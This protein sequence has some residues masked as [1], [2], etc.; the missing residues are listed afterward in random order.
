MEESKKQ[1]E[2]LAKEHEQMALNCEKLD[3]EIHEKQVKANRENGS[4]ILSGLANLAGKGRYALLEA[5]NK[6]LKKQVVA[7]PQVVAQQVETLTITYKEEITKERNRADFW[8]AECNKQERIYKGLLTQSKNREVDLKQELQQRDNII[9][10]MRAG[11]TDF[12]RGFTII[13]QNAINAVIDF[14]HD[15]KLQH[16]TFLE[17][18]LYF[19]PF[20]QTGLLTLAII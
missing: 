5:E 17:K 9:A 8:L 10:T 19:D 16:F 3:R 20:G 1:A 18:P 2:K 11:L 12:L 13:C 6:E 4:A 15:T 14:A 7:I